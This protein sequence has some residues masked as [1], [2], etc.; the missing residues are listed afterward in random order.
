MLAQKTE[1]LNAIIGGREEE[2]RQSFRSKRF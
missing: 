2:G 1:L